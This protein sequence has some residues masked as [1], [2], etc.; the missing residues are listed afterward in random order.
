MYDYFDEALWNNVSVDPEGWVR[1][2]IMEREAKVVLVASR[3]AAINNKTD[4]VTYRNP[5]AFDHL[6]P[7]IIKLL[8]DS[9]NENSY[10]NH[11]VVT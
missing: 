6:F 7:Y 8:R 9:P 11:F 4:A 2:L 3:A 10:R 1:E 5:H